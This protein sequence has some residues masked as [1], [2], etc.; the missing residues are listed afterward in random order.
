MEALIAL[1]FIIIL[2][3]IINQNSKLFQQ[4]Q[5]MENEL[6][7]LKNNFNSFSPL[8]EEKKQT[9][10]VNSKPFPP[11]YESIF[12]EAENIKDVQESFIEIKNEQAAFVAP[13][14]QKAIPTENKTSENI[15]HTEPLKLLYKPSFFERHPDMEKF[16]GENLVNKIGI[17]ILVLA[18]GFFVKY[19]ID[20]NW[21]GPVG[22]VSIG[23]LCGAILVGIAHKMRNSYISFSSVLAGGGLA[24]FYFTIT[25][26]YHQFKLFDQTTAF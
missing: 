6:K 3:V 1:L 8:V 5:K 11:P 26:A 20:Q 23:I 13:K 18:I 9:P 7:K 2:I 25:L 10:V 21:V 19:A 4:L 22:R 15:P 17:A 14:E 24:V 16:I 12:S